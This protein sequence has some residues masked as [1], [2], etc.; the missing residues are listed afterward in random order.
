MV[1]P[2]FLSGNGT[3]D[4]SVRWV[5]LLRWLVVFFLLDSVQE[6]P[7]PVRDSLS[8]VI[9]TYVGMYISFVRF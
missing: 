2:F 9:C 1:H 6:A 7:D 8:L 5:G 3:L 4:V